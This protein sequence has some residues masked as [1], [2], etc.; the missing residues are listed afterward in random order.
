MNDSGSITALDMP[1]IELPPPAYERVPRVAW[2]IPS[3]VTRS[4]H[5]PD[6]AGD[7][8]YH[9]DGLYQVG[10]LLS[11]WCISSYVIQNLSELIRREVAASPDHKAIDQCDPFLSVLRVPSQQKPLEFKQPC[12]QHL[13]RW[14]HWTPPWPSLAPINAVHNLWRYGQF[15]QPL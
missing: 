3:D 10:I 2:D 9:R 8:L 1:S 14:R 11:E 5:S 13:S 4:P 15:D 12:M 6:V 7:V